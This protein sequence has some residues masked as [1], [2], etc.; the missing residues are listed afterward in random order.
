MTTPTTDPNPHELA[1]RRALVTGGSRGIGAAIARRLIDAG[2]TVVTAA[3]TATDDTPPKSTFIPA[4]LRTAA[5]VRE[6]AE[7]AVE[8][9]GG[10]DILIDNAGAGR[11]FPQGTLSIPDE[12]WQESLD[13]NLL[14]AIRLDAA[15]LPGMRERGTGSIVHI[16]STVVHDPQA[17]FL[18]YTA[19]KAA[20]NAYSRGLAL[21]QAPAG[22]RV[23]AVL[24]G[25][26]TTPGADV[27]RKDI[28]D[29]TGTDAAAVLDSIPL[30][31]IG[32]PEDIAEM[33]AFLVSDR[34]SW[35]TGRLFT[36]DGGGF[37]QG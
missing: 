27:V 30:G 14:A 8:Q 4:D 33:V 5:G 32:Q 9:L 18:H 1:G 24:P 22:I 23:N 13:I 19:A 31:R 25:N 36:V 7:A 15:L 35:I 29:A 6:L 2:A 21:E 16:S 20:L 37:P 3:R 12:H 34:A 26:V 11:L 28:A 10:V 17:P